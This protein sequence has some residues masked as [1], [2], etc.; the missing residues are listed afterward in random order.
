MLPLFEHQKR[1]I[2]FLR[3]KNY[4]LDFSDPGTGKT[5]VQ[6]ELFSE[7]RRAGGGCA[8]VIAPKSLLRSAWAD[9]FAKFSP[10]IKT[11]VA[12]ANNRESAFGSSA[13][14]YI[15]NTDA[16]SWLA[17]KPASFF[18]KFDTLIVDELSNFKHRT[19]LLTLLKSILKD[20][21]VLLGLLMPI[22]LLTYG[23]RLTWSIMES[24]SVTASSR[25]EV[26][27]VSPSRSDRNRTWSSG[28][29]KR[30]PRS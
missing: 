28:S 2:E 12:T 18:S 15:T 10:G 16:V 11:V 13:D 17:K 26:P 9:D 8:L 6:I 4:A 27:F 3:S 19:K 25:L 24:R 5:R 20:A 21:M 22:I 7:R 14:V 30:E 1:S 23:T 29:A